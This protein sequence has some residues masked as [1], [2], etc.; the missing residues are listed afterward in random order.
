M[1][2]PMSAVEGAA[3]PAGRGGRGRGRRAGGGPSVAARLAARAGGGA[4]RV[5]LVLV[6]LFWLMPSV[7]LLLSSL[8]SPAQI[9]E[10]GWW[11]VFTRPAQLTFDNYGHL[12]SNG[13]V[14]GSLVTTAAITVPSTVLVVVIGSLAGY[15]FAW[16]E[17]PGRDA[18]F[19]VVVGLLVVPV[20]VA[21]IP[22]AKLFGAVGLFETTAGVVLFHT[23]FGL[24]FAVFLLRNFFAEIPRELLEAARL[25]G[26]GELRLFTR[27]VMPLGGP[28]IASLGIFQFLWVWNDMLIALIFADSGHPP[29]T[30]ALQQ[31]VRQFGNNIDVLAPGAFLSMVVPLV[32]FFAF[33]RQFVS[34]V[35][36]GAVK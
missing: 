25:D 28:A 26:A 24:P 27:V 35:M 31:E 9:A 17:F 12:L 34:G 13:K 19:M 11:Q 33:Q 29:I 21:L 36:A 32:V 6:A 10:S 20:Q 5:F 23:A 22:V 30:V 3:V 4:V 14:M 8:R 15:A 2:S 18:W 1:T 7:G 16:L